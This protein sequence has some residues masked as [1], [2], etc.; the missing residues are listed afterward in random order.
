M[1]PV[2]EPMNREEMGD[3]GLVS[4]TIT[5]RTERPAGHFTP[6]AVPNHPSAHVPL[7]W[8]RIRWPE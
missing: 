1:A 7:E 4:Y 2:C 8:P 6:R 5:L 3:D